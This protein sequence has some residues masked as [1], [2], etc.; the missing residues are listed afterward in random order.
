MSRRRPDDDDEREH[1]QE[2]RP[3]RPAPPPRDEDDEEERPRRRRAADDEDEG[4]PRRRRPGDDDGYSGVV[5]YR[6]MFAL[7]AY[8]LGFLGIIAILGGFAFILFQGRQ[9]ALPSPAR[10]AI[11]TFGVIYGLGGIS[12]LLAIIFGSVGLAKAS[13]GKGTAHAIVGIVLGALEI[14]GLILILLLGLLAV[15]R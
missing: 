4:P 1:V 5:P 13:K 7:T 12:A 6:N 14:I 11:V 3:R 2:G 10:V 8:Y 9:G 15:R